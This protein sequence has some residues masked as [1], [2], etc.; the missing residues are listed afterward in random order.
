[1]SDQDIWTG[2][3]QKEGSFFHSSVLVLG[4]VSRFSVWLVGHL[5]RIADVNSHETGVGGIVICLD[6]KHSTI[7][8][9]ELQHIYIH[10]R[11]T[12]RDLWTDRQTV[13]I[14]QCIIM[15]N[16]QS[17]YFKVVVINGYKFQ[18]NLK[19]VGLACINIYDFCKTFNRFVW[20]QIKNFVGIYLSNNCFS[21]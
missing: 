17:T 6:C 1:M 2:R 4:C 5:V 21:R 13:T 9:N 8:G 7:I 18:Q 12:N 20:E 11:C 16:S 15:C 10:E 14:E 3:E 19:L